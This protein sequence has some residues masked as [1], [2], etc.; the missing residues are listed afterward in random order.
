MPAARP[1]Q[2][3]AGRRHAGLAM[4]CLVLRRAMATRDLRSWARVRGGRVGARGGG[5]ARDSR[6]REVHGAETDVG[7]SVRGAHV[8]RGPWRECT[9]GCPPSSRCQLAANAI[10]VF[11][12]DAVCSGDRGV[13][14]ILGPMGALLP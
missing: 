5:E 8:R 13:A 1:C 14:R 3:A 6:R 4:Y 10:G 2:R 9:R 11:E 7:G 12:L